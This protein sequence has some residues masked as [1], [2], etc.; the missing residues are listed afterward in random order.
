VVGSYAEYIC[1]P[2]EELIAI[3]EGLDPAEAVSLVLNYGTAYQM[4]HRS[5]QVQS[6]DRIL[7]HGAAGGVGTAL[8]QLCGLLGLEMY[9]TASQKKHHLVSSL[10]CTPIDYKKVDFVEEIRQLTGEGVDVVFDGIG[11]QHIWRSYKTLRRGGRVVAFGHATSLIDRTLTGGRR[12]RL[13]GLPTIAGYIIASFLIPDGKKI[14]LYSIQTLKRRKPDWFREDMATLFGL[15]S[16]GQISPV[17]ADC[18]PLAEA[19]R[20]HELLG[21]GSVTGKIVLS[22]SI[23]T[24]TPRPVSG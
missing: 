2:A 24:F 15:L 9:G 7:I 23:P 18:L 17:I 11:G 21:T 4:I 8:L 12:S 3:P 16:R 6:G 1:L 5:A 13:R 19:A 10:G 14:I 22:V 20:V